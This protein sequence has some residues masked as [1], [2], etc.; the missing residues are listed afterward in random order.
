M[1]TQ[2]L[3]IHTQVPKI[4][5]CLAIIVVVYKIMLLIT[6]DLY[7]NECGTFSLQD[8]CNSAPK[9]F[10]LLSSSDL[11]LGSVFVWAERLGGG[12]TWPGE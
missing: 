2:Q 11:E 5:E 1:H 6:I 12:V 7:K 9:C 3:E 10:N 4:T 8:V